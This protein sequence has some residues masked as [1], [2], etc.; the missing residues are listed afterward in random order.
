MSAR[1]SVT[2]LHA[3]AVAFVVTGRG[4]SGLV[5]GDGGRL[6]TEV[7]ERAIA[8]KTARERSFPHRKV[9]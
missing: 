2:R 1:E 6:D 7:A 8:D 4:R 3:R 9:D 5:I